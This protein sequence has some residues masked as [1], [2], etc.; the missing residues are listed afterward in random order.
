MK[1]LDIH[2]D[3]ATERRLQVIAHELRR[4]VRELAECAVAEAALEFFRGRPIKEDPAH[5][6][7]GSNLQ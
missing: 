6:P 4:E 5:Q 7:A 3:D 1:H 2:I